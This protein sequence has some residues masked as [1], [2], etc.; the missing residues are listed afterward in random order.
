MHQQSNAPSRLSRRVSQSPNTPTR[1][2]LKAKYTQPRGFLDSV[3]ASQVVATPSNTS[4]SST[5]PIDY[6]PGS[7]DIDST[8]DLSSTR[9]ELPSDD[10]L[11]SNSGSLLRGLE[12]MRRKGTI[13]FCWHLTKRAVCISWEDSLSHGFWIIYLLCL[14]HQAKVRNSRVPCRRSNCRNLSGTGTMPTRQQQA[15]P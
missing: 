8:I 6:S 13:P 3:A 12:Q 1:S 15:P 7:D 10:E 4:R 14:L 11:E 2:E 5:S 9:L